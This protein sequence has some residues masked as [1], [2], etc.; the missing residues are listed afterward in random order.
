MLYGE[1][2]D[3]ND[4]IYTAKWNDYAI[5]R[6]EK[7]CRA[8]FR[9]LIARVAFAIAVNLFLLD[10]RKWSRVLERRLLLVLLNACCDA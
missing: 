6:N 10:I 1:G 7:L 9:F 8:G 2:I 3:K 5:R 4:F